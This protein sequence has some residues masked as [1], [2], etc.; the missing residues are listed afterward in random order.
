MKRQ[1][2]IIG[3]LIL[4]VNFNVARALITFHSNL[5][6]PMEVYTGAA[7]FNKNIYITATSSVPTLEQHIFVVSTDGPRMS[8]QADLKTTLMPNNQ[9][10]R[11]TPDRLG[12]LLYFDGRYKSRNSM[13]SLSMSNLRAPPRKIDFPTQRTNRLSPSVC[14]LPHHHHHHHHHHHL[15]E[16][17]VAVNP[18]A[19]EAYVF[20][21]TS[22]LYVVD[23]QSFTIKRSVILAYDTSAILL[24]PTFNP[25]DNLLYGLIVSQVRGSVCNTT[26]AVVVINPTTGSVL[27][28]WTGATGSGMSGRSL[29]FHPTLPGV[30]YVGFA[31]PFAGVACSFDTQIARISIAEK[32]R[33]SDIYV[34]HQ[35][36]GSIDLWTD[37]QGQALYSVLDADG[38]FAVL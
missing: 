5:T 30:V 21:Q 19:Q 26:S 10:F 33:F 31:Q 2:F 11:P 32:P 25:V 27:P 13:Y 4:F 28:M 20:G 12:N 29:S 16:W 22:I 18:A 9:L 7:F 34:S 37:V 35:G 14:S 15:V 24:D 6:V 3:V 1:L 8:I 23:L 17:D 38:T 36:R